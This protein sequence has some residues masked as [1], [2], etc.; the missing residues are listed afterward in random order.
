M[1]ENKK[2]VRKTAT[3]KAAPKKTAP[4]KSSLETSSSVDKLQMN[5]FKMDVLSKRNKTILLVVIGLILLGIIIFVNRGLFIAALVN[6]EPI[7]R[8]A[9]IGDLEKQH[10]AEALNR[11][12]DKKLILQEA[13]KQNLSPTQEDIDAKRKEIVDQ[14]SG[15]DEEN[16]KQILSSQGLSEEDF[17]EELKIQIVAEKMLSD[18][19]EVTDEEFNQ[20]VE[21]NPDLLENAEDQEAAA[22]SLREQLKQQKLQTEYSTW[23]ENLRKDANVVNFVNY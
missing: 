16:F 21:N 9:V 3:G 1:A 12:I 10:G 18:N 20:F 19:V 5:P 2:P 7:S 6:G 23:I 8:I 14:V 17:S 15:G 13:E 4:K 11:M 22:A